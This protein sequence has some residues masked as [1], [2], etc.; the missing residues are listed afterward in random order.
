MKPEQKFITTLREQGERL[1]SPRLAIF[2][3]LVARAPLST[4]ELV[5]LGQAQAIDQATTYR[6]LQL[7]RAMG[8][9]KDIV[10]GG[11]RQLELTDQYTAHHDHFRC[12]HCG[13]LI[14]IED[15]DLELA[16]R[17]TARRLGA[18]LSGHQLEMTGLCANCQQ[19]TPSQHIA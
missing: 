12:S 2:Q 1:S 9:A 11:Q 15:A 5:A 16:L 13:R 14:D 3:L 18:T 6:T 8:I 10:S 19:F 17:E 7:F 4:R